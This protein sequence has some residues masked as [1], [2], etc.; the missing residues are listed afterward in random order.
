M[1]C[2]VF[3][4][5]ILFY[6]IPFSPCTDRPHVPRNV[7][8]TDQ[9]KDFIV[10]EWDK[11]D[12]DGGSPIT[13][14][15]VEKREASR[16]MWTGISETSADTL[17]VKATRLSE[18]SEYYFRIAAVNSIGQGPFGIMDDSVTAKLPFS[19]CWYRR[20]HLTFAVLYSENIYHLSKWKWSG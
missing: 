17:K 10:I 2:Q 18:G 5:C 14:Y 13:G 9:Y 7:R 4:T 19:K 6:Q 15:V 20:H 12:N 11:P 8:V 1:F 16:K 3:V